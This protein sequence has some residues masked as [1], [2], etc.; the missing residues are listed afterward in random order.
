MADMKIISKVVAIKS[1][2]EMTNREAIKEI[3]VLSEKERDEL[4]NLC[5]AEMP[6]VSLA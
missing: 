3:A 6:G 2:F 1:F 5:I 4:A